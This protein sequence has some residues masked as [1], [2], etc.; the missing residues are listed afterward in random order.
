MCRTK[1][2]VYCASG[3]VESFIDEDEDSD[4]DNEVDDD[5]DTPSFSPPKSRSQ[6]IQLPLIKDVDVHAVDDNTP[7]AFRLNQ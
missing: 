3:Y 4:S 7:E 2:I 5:G 1:H 6:Y